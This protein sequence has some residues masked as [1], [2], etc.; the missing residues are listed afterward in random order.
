MIG[1]K[2]ILETSKFEN[3]AITTEKTLLLMIRK[4]EFFDALTIYKELIFAQL[5]IMSGKIAS[6]GAEEEID[7]S[8]F[9]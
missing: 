6:D 9:G 8:L 7:F 3:T 1:E 4:E 2:I 5:N